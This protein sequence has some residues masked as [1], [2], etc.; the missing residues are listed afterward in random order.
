MTDIGQPKKWRRYE[1][2]EEPTHEEP[3]R[4]VEAPEEAPV[5]PAD[6]TPAREPERV[7]V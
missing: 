2:V 7:P 3:S 4:E 5:T 6:P 1:P